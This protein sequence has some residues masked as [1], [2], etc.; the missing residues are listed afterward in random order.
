[1]QAVSLA[2]R[3]ATLYGSALIP[4]ELFFARAGIL[5]GL[6]IDGIEP[7]FRKSAEGVHGLFH[8]R[9]GHPIG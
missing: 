7:L 8:L 6:G 5:D 4:A 2:A 9:C 1:M 3:Q